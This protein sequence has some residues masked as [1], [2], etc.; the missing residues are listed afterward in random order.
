MEISGPVKIKIK[1]TLKKAT[2]YFHLFI[3]SKIVI[4]SLLSALRSLQSYRIQY[5]AKSAKG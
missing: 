4:E 2:S 1:F 5:G 3:H